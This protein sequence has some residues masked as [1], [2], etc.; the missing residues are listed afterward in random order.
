MATDRLSGVSGSNVQLKT[1]AG[2]DWLLVATVLVA[3]VV[4]GEGTLAAVGFREWCWMR[5]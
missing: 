4:D 1:G 2:K 5:L 3:C